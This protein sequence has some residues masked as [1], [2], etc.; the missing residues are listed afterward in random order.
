MADSLSYYHTALNGCNTALY[1]CSTALCGCNAAIYGCRRTLPE[2]A[3]PSQPA[4]A[5]FLRSLPIRLHTVCTTRS[6]RT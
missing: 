2:Y 3:A 6:L 5:M 4:Q 1:G